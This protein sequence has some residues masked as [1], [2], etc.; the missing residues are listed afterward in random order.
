MS[1]LY[2]FLQNLLRK[3]Q[4]ILE[5]NSTEIN[6]RILKI[7]RKKTYLNKNKELREI[8]NEAGVIPRRIY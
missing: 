4:K 7:F 1:I 2:L 8:L 5:Y 3:F 6:N